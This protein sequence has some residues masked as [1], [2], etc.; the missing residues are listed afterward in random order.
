MEVGLLGNKDCVILIQARIYST[1]L[2]GKILFKFFD[3]TIIE[4][5]IK[6]AKEVTDSKNIFIISGSKKKK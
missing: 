3:N 2:P 6:I 1:R 4:R 5:V